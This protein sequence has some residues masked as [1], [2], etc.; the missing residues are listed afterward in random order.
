MT[1]VLFLAQL[2]GNSCVL[3]FLLQTLYWCGVVTLSDNNSVVYFYIY[4]Y[5]VRVVVFMSLMF[6]YVLC[7]A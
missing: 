6:T 7:R 2:I 5:Y 4:T 3:Y 1:K